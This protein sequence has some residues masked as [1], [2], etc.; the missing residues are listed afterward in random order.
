MD[1]IENLLFQNSLLSIK[2]DRIK[3]NDIK[4]KN[5]S[6]QKIYEIIEHI[7]ELCYNQCYI[8]DSNEKVPGDPFIERNLPPSNPTIITKTNVD[9]IYNLTLS[10]LQKVYGNSNDHINNFQ[11]QLSDFNFNDKTI[12]YKDILQICIA[13][14]E[15]IKSEIQLGL[16]NSIKNE[17]TGEIVADFLSLARKSLTEDIVE[18]AAVLSCASLEDTLKRYARLNDLNVDE[19]TMTEV[20]NALKSKG[21]LS[22]AQDS[23]LKGYAKI[24][25]KVFHADWDKIEKSDISSIVGFTEEFVLKHFSG[26]M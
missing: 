21:L 9:L 15:F 23:I 16:V 18:V 20:I 22:S 5:L 14:L 24:R 7:E 11:S 8:K 4:M 12:E 13:K 26:S 17:V 6:E 10:L 25:N 1:I 2:K 3:K 19:K